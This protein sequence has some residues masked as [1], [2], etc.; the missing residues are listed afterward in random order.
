[1]SEL[2]EAKE[3]SIIELDNNSSVSAEFIHLR[4]TYVLRFRAGELS[5]T[6]AVIRIAVRN[7]YPMINGGV[8][9]RRT[10]EIQLFLVS[11][12]SRRACARTG[13][14]LSKYVCR[15]SSTRFTFTRAFDISKRRWKIH[16]H[17]RSRTC[18]SRR[19][20]R[21][22]NQQSE[23]VTCTSRFCVFVKILIGA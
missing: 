20:E 17:S 18:S 22:G 4:A 15:S 7:V 23:T 12:K 6:S 21:A 8:E 19:D 11:D 1:M 16:I 2:K 13:S 5:L 9:L 10:R 14:V 3:R